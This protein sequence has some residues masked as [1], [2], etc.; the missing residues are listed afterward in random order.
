MLYDALRNRPTPGARSS[1]AL[2][3]GELVAKCG[4]I[5]TW[6]W[7]H[8]AADC[9]P[10][11]E[12][13][14]QW[15]RRWK[16]YFEERGAQVEVVMG[17]HRA[18]VVMPSGLIIEL[19]HDYLSTFDIAEREQF[20]GSHLAWIYRAAWLE[21]LHWGPKGFWWKHGCKAMTAHRRP[22]YWDYGDEVAR[23]QVSVAERKDCYG[24]YKGEPIYG[25]SSY[26]VL[27]RVFDVHPGPGQDPP[28]EQMDIFGGL[29]PRDYNSVANWIEAQNRSRAA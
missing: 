16:A 15:H 2:C 14:T 21:R 9:D 22:L 27:G 28:P 20:Y 25:P 3:D 7:A 17:P 19:Q 26:R 10:W 18:D 13:E 5:V 6:H 29:I 23:V 4:Q 11:S 8:L 1:C 12:P 24:D